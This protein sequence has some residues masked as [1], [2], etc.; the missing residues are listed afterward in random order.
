MMDLRFSSSKLTSSCIFETD[1]QHQK[2]CKG[3]VWGKKIT[4][5]SWERTITYPLHI[6][7]ELESM[8]F[9]TLPFGGSHVF[10]LSWRVYTLK[11]LTARHWKSMLGRL[12]PKEST[13]FVQLPGGDIGLPAMLFL[14]G[15][16]L[17]MELMEEIRLTTKDNDDPH[18][19]LGFLCMP[20]GC[21]GFLPST[22]Y[23]AHAFF[24]VWL[25]GQA[26][27]KTPSVHTSETPFLHVF[28]CREFK[29]TNHHICVKDLIISFD[30]KWKVH[31]G[32]VVWRLRVC[33][34]INFTPINTGWWKKSQTNTRDLKIPVNYGMINH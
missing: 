26:C 21:L 30:T 13:K 1:C 32:W 14:G 29:A 22:I 31:V 8:L 3:H 4:V 23:V 2:V 12:S 7:N 6:G 27:Q 33:S 18:Y 5:P 16:C 15:A 28:E 9:R 11:S 24:Q 25:V 17:P 34:A 20:G 10:I 19:L